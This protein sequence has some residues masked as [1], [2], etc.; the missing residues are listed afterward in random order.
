[1]DAGFLGI[2]KDENA[3][4]N[5]GEIARVT[6]FPKLKKLY[7]F[8]LEEVEEWDGIERKV[9]EEDANTNSITIMPQL[10]YLRIEYCHLLRALPD[11]VLAAPLQALGIRDCPILRKRYWKEEMGEDWQK[12]SHIPNISVI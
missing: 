3:S 1:L 10:Q 7:I 12:I 11:Y 4:I 8:E 9:E 6:A 5:E 2:E